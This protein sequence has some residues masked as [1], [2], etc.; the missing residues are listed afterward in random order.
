MSY[1]NGHICDIELHPCLEPFC[2]H[3]EWQEQKRDAEILGLTVEQL[4]GLRRRRR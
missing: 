4:E 1:G 3:R 2:A